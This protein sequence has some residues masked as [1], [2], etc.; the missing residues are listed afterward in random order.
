M[1]ESGMDFG[2]RRP[3]ETNSLHFSQRRI[4]ISTP[5]EGHDANTICWLVSDVQDVQGPTCFGMGPLEVWNLLASCQM[6]RKRFSDAFPRVGWQR[7]LEID[8][9]LSDVADM[10]LQTPPQSGCAVKFGICWFLVRCR[11]SVS[12][13][14]SLE[15]VCSKVWNLLVPC[16]MSRKCLSRPA[17][18]VELQ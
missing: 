1:L 10:S 4:S 5:Q 18:R 12:P 15:W 16:Q 8:G 17:P 13:D 2:M 11:G 14:V 9:F 6:S 3:V 7:G